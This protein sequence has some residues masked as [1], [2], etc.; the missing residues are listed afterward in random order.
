LAAQADVDLYTVCYGAPPATTALDAFCRTVTVI[1]LYPT[2]HR[3]QLVRAWVDGRPRSVRYFQ[4][5]RSLETIRTKLIS[6]A[7]DLLICDEIC[8]ATYFDD[9]HYHHNTP[10]LIMRQKIDYL[11]YQETA[12]SRP[13][14]I[15]RSLEALEARRLQRFEELMMPRFDGAIVCSQGDADVASTQGP[16]LAIEIIVNGADVDY[17]APQVTSQR[18]PDPKPTILLLGTMHYQPNVDMVLYFFRTIY[19]QLCQAVPDLQVLIVG[20]LPPPEVRALGNLPGVTVTG[21]VDDVRPYMAHSWLLAVPLRL[22]GGTRLKIVEAMAANLA[23]I[24]T[25]VG[26]QGLPHFGP[27]ALTIADT[28]EAFVQ[29]ATLLL[30]DETRRATQA[31]LA[32]PIVQSHYSWQALGHKFAKFCGQLVQ[33][34]CNKA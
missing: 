29:G 7:Y 31:K 27:D 17:F 34:S 13:W 16:N 3:E 10:R 5:P 18:Q 9:L 28:P 32:R 24:S 14:G 4:D 8:M 1:P 11:H 2:P 15:Q 26:A 6:N 21:S 25:S 20:H 22:G 19:P 30:Q 33:Q 23:V 12:E